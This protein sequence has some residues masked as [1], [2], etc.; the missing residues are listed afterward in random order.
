MVGWSSETL[1]H[2]SSNTDIHTFSWIFHVLGVRKIG[3]SLRT[4]KHKI[5]FA[6]RERQGDKESPK[7]CSYLKSCEPLDTCP[8]GDCSYLKSCEPLDTC[9]RAPFYRETK[10]LFTFR[11]YS[12]I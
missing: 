8:R 6:I 7:D 5:Q 10:G 1:T 9:P 12:R 11:K 2:Q 4:Q 3:E